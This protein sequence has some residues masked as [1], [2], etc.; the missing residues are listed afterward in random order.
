V[1]AGSGRK[2]QSAIARAEHSRRSRNRARL[3]DSGAY[4]AIG[5]APHAEREGHVP[6]T[7]RV[8]VFYVSRKSV[9]SGRQLNR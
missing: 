5:T 7:L 1:S 3:L 2:G 4:F 8:R 9:T 6:L